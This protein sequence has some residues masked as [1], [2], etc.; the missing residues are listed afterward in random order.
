MSNNILYVAP[1]TGSDS[2][3]DGAYNNPYKTIAGA[4]AVYP[5]NR[6]DGDEIRV[7]KSG[8]NT[9]ISGTVTWTDGST[10]VTKTGGN[11]AAES[12][13]VGKGDYIGNTTIG[14]WEVA[15]VST[16]TC[17][18]VKAF[19]GTTGAK[20]T[21]RLTTFDITTT[22]HFENL[23]PQ[24]NAAAFGKRPRVSGGWTLAASPTQDG[25]TN[26]RYY[27]S[28]NLDDYNA[29]YAGLYIAAGGGTIF[30][31]LSFYHFHEGIHIAPSVHFCEFHYC[32]VGS[33]GFLIQGCGHK[34]YNCDSIGNVEAAYH[35]NGYG[36][37]GDQNEFHTCRA[38]GNTSALYNGNTA[39]F[40]LSGCTAKFVDCVA[41]GNTNS[42]LL[43]GDTYGGGGGVAKCHNCTLDIEP[44]LDKDDDNVWGEGWVYCNKYNGTLADNRSYNILGKLSS[45][46]GVSYGHTA[47]GIAWLM[48]PTSLAAGTLATGTPFRVPVG[49]ISVVAN[50]EFTFTLWVKKSHASSI[51]CQLV[52]KGGLL[53]GIAADVVG[54]D[55]N[56]TNWQQL[57]VTATPTETAVAEFYLDCIGSGQSVYFDDAGIA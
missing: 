55:A 33:G 26:Y 30:E 40:K 8:A 32:H 29:S 38:L 44:A 24:F 47:S 14:F 16:T 22:G 15:A 2:T 17:T 56:N 3:G 46:S 39:G 19:A 36:I 54:A 37:D 11:W 18:L 10:S 57:S 34:F 27:N 48:E 12:P 28:G 5:N 13:A 7:K 45:V 35:S 42:I 25:V 52:L 31:K 49:E 53:A 9:S 43:G 20:S 41:D 50:V 21:E 23:S 6:N 1:D 51:D 4:M